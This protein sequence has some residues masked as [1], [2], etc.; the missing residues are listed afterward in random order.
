M[1]TNVETFH[2]F[3]RSSLIVMRV[4]TT[5]QPP[6]VSVMGAAL[7]GPDGDFLH[8]S[9]FYSGSKIGVPDIL[10]DPQKSNMSSQAMQFLSDCTFMLLAMIIKV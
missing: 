4:M 7:L 5:E 1:W 9:M 2:N 10:G 6:A 8:H 3:N